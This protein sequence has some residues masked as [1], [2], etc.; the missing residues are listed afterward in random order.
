MEQQKSRNRNGIFFK[1][2]LI[3]STDHTL[4]FD[5]IPLF[6]SQLWMPPKLIQ[7]YGYFVCLFWLDQRSTMSTS[8]F[9]STHSW[10][11]T[12]ISLFSFV[13]RLMWLFCT[14]RFVSF[15]LVFDYRKFS[16]TV[17]ISVEN[18]WSD[19]FTLI[20]FVWICYLHWIGSFSQLF[21]KK[22]G[23]SDGPNA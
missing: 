16:W 18:K 13:A 4:N 6:R 23:I 21:I 15:L 17:R 9:S 12:N 14:F 2:L 19:L 5:N 11:S 10:S 8:W 3:F 7:L 1:L 20:F 22:L